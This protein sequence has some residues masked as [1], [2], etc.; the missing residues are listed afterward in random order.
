[1]RIDSAG[2]INLGSGGVLAGRS[3]V[4]TKNITGGTSGY[5]LFNFGT[6]Q[7]DVTTEA[8]YF[9]TAASTVNSSFTVGNIKHYEALQATFGAS[10]TVTN[11]FGFIAGNNLTG[12]TNNFGFYSNIASGSGRW[13]FYANGTAANYMAGTLQTGSTIGVGGATPAASG[14]GISFP[15][16]QSASSDANTLDDYEEG[17][18]T[19][20]GNGVTLTVTNATYT[21]I[22]RVVNLSFDITWP[23][24]ANGNNADI[25]NL[26]FT[27]ATS[28]AGGVSIGYNTGTTGIWWTSGGSTEIASFSVTNA[29]MS[30]DRMIASVTYF[31]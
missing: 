7:S 22:G 12:A 21:K 2:N 14:A 18:W 20:T 25:Q 24:T 13:N 23:N 28:G 29:N 11:Q 17:T 5:A 16:T 10:S 8:V 4:I 15:A 1:M 26:P 27:V 19:P 3:V 31:V 30:T 9:R 6:V